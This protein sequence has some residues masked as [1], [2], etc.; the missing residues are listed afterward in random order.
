M[1]WLRDF[2]RGFNDS[3][4]NSNVQNIHGDAVNAETRKKNDDSGNPTLISTASSESDSR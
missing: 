4:S 3:D 2:L 1:S